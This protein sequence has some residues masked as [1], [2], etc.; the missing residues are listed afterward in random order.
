MRGDEYIAKILK[1]EGVEWLSAGA[2]VRPWAGLHVSAPARHA[3]NDNDRIL[4]SLDRSR[5]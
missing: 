1:D 5:T 2:E 3:D 4:D